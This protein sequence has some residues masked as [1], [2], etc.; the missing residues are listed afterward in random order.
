MNELVD[1]TMQ[2]VTAY[3]PGITD[4]TLQ[5]RLRHLLSYVRCNAQHY[6]HGAL[7]QSLVIAYLTPVTTPTRRPWAG[8]R[9]LVRLEI[10]NGLL[11][12]LRFEGDIEPALIQLDCIATWL[13]QNGAQIVSINDAQSQLSAL[14]NLNRTNRPSCKVYL[15]PSASI[16][17]T[18][19]IGPRLIEKIFLASFNALRNEYGLPP[20]PD[21]PLPLKHHL[22]AMLESVRTTTRNFLTALNQDALTLIDE[23]RNTYHHRY[24][25]VTAYNFLAEHCGAHSRNR[26]QAMRALPWLL[27]PLSKMDNLFSITTEQFTLPPMI[28]R[29]A[30]REIVTA[31]DLGLPLFDAVSRIFNVPGETV[32]WS[33]HQMLP[34]TAQFNVRSLHFLMAVL[35]CLPREK[36]P[37]D[38]DQWHCMKTVVCALLTILGA[39]WDGGGLATVLMN[40]QQFRPIFRHWLSQLMR[41]DWASAALRIQT[42]RE[43]GEDEHALKDF[44]GVLRRAMRPADTASLVDSAATEPSDDAFLAWLARQSLHTVSRLSTAW[45]TAIANL[46]RPRSLDPVASHL[47]LVK[48]PALLDTPLVVDG[49]QIVELTTSMSLLEEGQRMAHCA[50]GY[51]TRCSLGTAFIFS[52]RTVKGT[53]LSTVELGIHEHT[54]RVFLKQHKGRR[55]NPP[56]LTCTDIVNRLIELLN[57]ISHRPILVMRQEYSDEMR[58]RSMNERNRVARQVTDY[59]RMAQHAAWELTFGTALPQS[60]ALNRHR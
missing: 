14:I 35:S 51:V 52:V 2:V 22:D 37:T 4:P 45:H 29:R 57:S 41:P 12:A 47:P 7:R 34:N 54:L 56:S 5:L 48:W 43:V 46:T 36:R 20:L 59:D 11:Y 24:D 55:N 27:R 44:L 3:F 21:L 17:P 49:Y 13:T 60:D 26:T 32:R 6:S 9:A 1:I 53:P 58:A 31:I 19:A 30:A 39:C 28:K 50:G 10:A 42:M 38:D 16:A 8:A 23:F 15:H 25:D 33:R 40:E 18:S